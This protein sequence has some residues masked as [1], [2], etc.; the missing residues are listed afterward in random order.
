MIDYASVAFALGYLYFFLR[1]L[2]DDNK[3]IPLFFATLTCGVLGYLT[4]V[5]TMP[6]VVLPLTYFAVREVFRRISDHQDLS[7][8]ST[9]LFF[10]KEKHLLF[11][12]LCLGL[13]PFAVG[14]VWG[15]YSD[16]I[17]GLSPFTHFLT[18]DR[19][20]DWN[21]GTW[22]Q[23]LS[24]SNWL[25]F[26]GRVR[27]LLVPGMW[28]CFLP[29]G[30]WFIHK[31]SR[32]GRE[33]VYLTFLTCLATIFILFN[34]YHH[35]YYF[36]SISP[37]L[38]IIVGLGVYHIFFVVFRRKYWAIIP[39]IAVLVWSAYGAFPS[40]RQAYGTSYDHPLCKLGK[41]I[42]DQT[43]PD[44]CIIVADYDWRPTI[45]YYAKRKGFML[46]L[47]EGNES[48]KFFREHN[49]TTVVC[50]KEHPKLFSN[51]RHRQ[52]IG[53]SAGFD[54]Y[55]VY[56][57]SSKA[58]DSYRKIVL[59]YPDGSPIRIIPGRLLT[60]S[61]K[62]KIRSDC[63]YFSGYAIDKKNMEP[64]EAIVAF[65]DG[66][67]VYSGKTTLDLPGIVKKFNNPKLQKTG[68]EFTLPLSLLKGA[69]SSEVHVF[70][71]SRDGLASELR[72]YRKYR[73]LKKQAP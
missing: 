50:R 3:K 18:L 32:S 55:R 25:S 30:L 34:L 70:A 58:L 65:L 51:W 48:N 2:R 61:V 19:L 47:F 68:Y 54:V 13:V 72:H 24:V 39:A 62:S 44:E 66:K 9:L 14:M 49:F 20:S 69:S 40:I 56:G 12:L 17:R 16:H 6:T 33:F 1:W 42:S 27:G 46:R 37:F 43:R 73:S 38:A 63:V 71:V 29:L 57:Q 21:Y 59:K 15:M 36:I 5:T 64:P 26:F 7:W 52:K 22:S 10:S 11:S 8:R 35:D 31:Y 23:K 41:I 28:I 53:S 67:Q 4:K 60:G 45:L